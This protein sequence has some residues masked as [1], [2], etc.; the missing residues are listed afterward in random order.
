MWRE[1]NTKIRKADVWDFWSTLEA[2]SVSEVIST[3]ILVNREQLT[4]WKM[5]GSYFYHIAFVLL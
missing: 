5:Y 1:E 4:Y 2:K 3:G